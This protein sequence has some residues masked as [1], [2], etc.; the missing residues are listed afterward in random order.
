LSEALQGYAP[1]KPMVEAS[2]QLDIAKDGI[3]EEVNGHP[4]HRSEGDVPLSGNRAMRLI[5][6]RADDVKHF[7]VRIEAVNG[8]DHMVLNFS[9]I[10]LEYPDQE[11]FQP[12][13]GFTPY[14]SSVSLMNELI[15]RD[16]AFAKKNGQDLDEP[17]DVRPKNWHDNSGSGGPNY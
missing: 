16:A 17:I 13:D 8:P 2:G 6:W 14:A 10:R 1:I 15:V 11:L 7:P 3:Q 4:C 12:P 5:L 9:E